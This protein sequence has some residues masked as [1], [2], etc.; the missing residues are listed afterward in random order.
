MILLYKFNKYQKIYVYKNRNQQNF[1]KLIENYQINVNKM[2]KNNYKYYNNNMIIIV[3]I[4]DKL[5]LTIKLNN[6]KTIIN[7]NNIQIIQISKK[8]VK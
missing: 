7:I 2:D 1:N 3:K 4:Q 6:K 5:Q 8:I